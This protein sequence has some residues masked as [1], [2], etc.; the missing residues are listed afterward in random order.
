MGAIEKIDDILFIFLYHILEMFSMLYANL[1]SGCYLHL[2]I[3][4]RN[5]LSFIQKK[6]LMAMQNSRPEFRRLI[7][8][9]QGLEC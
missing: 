3:C 1:S 9:P 6:N 2:F 7:R 4:F 8:M 5:W